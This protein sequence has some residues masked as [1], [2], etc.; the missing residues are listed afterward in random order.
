MRL[1]LP[2]EQAVSQLKLQNGRLLTLTNYR[3]RYEKKVW[4]SLQTTSIMLEEVASCSMT[5]NLMLT[6]NYGYPTATVGDGTG[7]GDFVTE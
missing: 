5:R 4:G 2:G 7:G 6:A 3:V 1:S